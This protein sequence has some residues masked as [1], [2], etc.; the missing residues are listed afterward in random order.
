MGHLVLSNPLPEGSPFRFSEYD[1]MW[2]DAEEKNLVLLN[3]IQPS[4]RSEGCRR[5]VIN[6]VTSLLETE[7]GCKVFSFGSVPLKTY[8]PDGDIDLTA[9]GSSPQFD[10][11]Y[12][13]WTEAVCKVLEHEERIHVKEVKCIHAEVITRTGSLCHVPTSAFG[14]ALFAVSSLTP[15]IVIL[16][17]AVLSF[18]AGSGFGFVLG[19]G[20]SLIEKTVKA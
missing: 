13:A 8:L 6:Y 17:T 4:K 16:G 3:R 12:R 7:I 10:Q 5:D 2:K 19:C 1:E 11:N 18:G 15:F 14:R 9:I 20:S